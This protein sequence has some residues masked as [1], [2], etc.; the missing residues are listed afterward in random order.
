M[1]GEVALRR[2]NARVDFLVGGQPRG[3]PNCRDCAPAGFS[4]P[5]PAPYAPQAIETLSIACGAT[6]SRDVDE[7]HRGVTTSRC[8]LSQP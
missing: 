2:M 7:R 1:L 4:S 8:E 5:H 6:C 3:L